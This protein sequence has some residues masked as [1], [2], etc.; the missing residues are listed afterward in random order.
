MYSAQWNCFA[1]VNKYSEVQRRTKGCFGIERPYIIE[2][3]HYSSCV[4]NYSRDSFRDIVRLFD[5]Y[6]EKGILPYPGSALE[7]P[8]K[9][10]EIFSIIDSICQEKTKQQEKPQYPQRVQDKMDARKK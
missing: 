1:C 7:Q 8:A 2:D 3:I 10:M 9:M 6:K 5:T 4:G